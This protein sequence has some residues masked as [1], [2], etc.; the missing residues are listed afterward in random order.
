ME[1][2]GVAL[3]TEK[4]KVGRGEVERA[5]AVIDEVAHVDRLVV[6]GDPPLVS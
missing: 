3:R 2:G 5:G 4:A 6:P 1:A